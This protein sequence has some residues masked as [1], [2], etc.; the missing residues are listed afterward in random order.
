MS[1]TRTPTF[2]NEQYSLQSTVARRTSSFINKLP[3]QDFAIR[4]LGPRYT[5]SVVL[6]GTTRMRSFN[7]KYRG[8]DMPTDILAFPLNKKEGEIFLNPHTLRSKAKKFNMTLRDYTQYVFIHGLL[9]LKGYDHGR[10]MEKLEERWCQVFSIPH[11]TY[12][13]GVTSTTVL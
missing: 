10:T 6:I 12:T 1:P 8:K 2:K 4:I 5:L 9:H 11:P 7:K 3:L 13:E